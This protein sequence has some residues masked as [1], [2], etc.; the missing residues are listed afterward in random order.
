MRL[1]VASALVLVSFVAANKFDDVKKMY[2]SPLSHGIS[3]VLLWFQMIII[4]GF[5]EDID[6]VTWEDAIETALD[7]QK[8][9]FLL[10]HKTW[11]HAC[12]G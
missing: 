12:K 3:E 6:W 7:K 10:I 8:P 2:E 5:G 4:L 1:L 11:C 9:I